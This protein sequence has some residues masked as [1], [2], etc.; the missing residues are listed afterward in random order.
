MFKLFHLQKMGHEHVDII[1]FYNEIFVPSVKPLLAE[2]GPVGAD[3]RTNGDP[4]AGTA[5]NGKVWDP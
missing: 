2:L 5:N 4:E 1:T 3:T